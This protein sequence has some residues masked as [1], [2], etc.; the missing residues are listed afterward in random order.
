MAGYHLP[1]PITLGCDAGQLHDSTALAVVEQHG[2]PYSADFFEAV[3][4]TVPSLGRLALG[5]KYPDVAKH[6]VRVVKDIHAHDR[7]QGIFWVTWQGE[8][9]VGVPVRAIRIAI[10]VT[11]VG[12]GLYD[13]VKHEL[14]DYGTTVIAVTLTGTERVAKHGESWSVGKPAMVY[15]L[16]KLFNYQRIKM[17]PGDEPRALQ[18]ELKVFKIKQTANGSQSG[19]FR[20]GEHDDLTCSLGVA[21]LEPSWEEHHPIPSW[22]Q[23]R[24]YGDHVRLNPFC[25]IAA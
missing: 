23:G 18:E 8:E 13:S 14:G 3:R 22:C 4:Y 12:R 1:A 6:I 9:I 15:N 5:T 21:T 25:R 16:Q 10:D 2:D 7:E 17:P 20:V 19:A 24:S 11:G